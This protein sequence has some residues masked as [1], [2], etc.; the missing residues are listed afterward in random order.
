[1]RKHFFIKGNPTGGCR[2]SLFPNL[3]RRRRRLPGATM[4]MLLLVCL[5]LS[6]LALPASLYAQTPPPGPDIR[7]TNISMVQDTLLQVSYQDSGQPGSLTLPIDFL[8]GAVGQLLAHSQAAPPT[9]LPDSQ[10]APRKKPD[11]R[12]ETT[13][14]ANTRII[15]PESGLTYDVF[16]IAD[17]LIQ[18]RYEDETGEQRVSLPANVV[19]GIY[20]AHQALSRRHEPERI[21]SFLDVKRGYFWVNIIQKYNAWVVLF[22]GLVG[23]VGLTGVPLLLS[24]R[25]VKRERN[26]LIASRWRQMKERE[27]ERIHLAAE[28]HDGPVQVLQ[29][30]LNSYL[31]SLSKRVRVD[32]D[33][34]DINEVREKLQQVTSDLRN[35]S[36]ELRPPVLVHFGLDEA[37]RSY[38]DL[39]QERNP[40]LEFELDLDPENKMLQMPVRLALY[41]IAQEALTNIARHARARHVRV[42]FKLN[43][44]RVVLAIQDDG[45]GFTL[46]RR[47]IELEQQGH[48]GLSGI[49]ARAEAIGGSLEVE[50]AGGQGTMLRVI[51]PPPDTMGRKTR[52][53]H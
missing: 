3:L 48:L 7:I 40:N 8:A 1:M 13:K 44:K 21:E 52:E 26:E 51:A 32:E 28:L 19:A 4:P 25:K 45:C 2:L 10:A 24:I 17:S 9:G 30:I 34:S 35:I 23:I 12:K 31:P 49:A 15:S 47:W 37:L 14:K 50:T 18:I 33:Q 27:K 29:R 5:G 38:L 43:A 39:F 22:I 20:L 11:T 6:L 16:M 42:T 41:R 46:P 36:T 53:G